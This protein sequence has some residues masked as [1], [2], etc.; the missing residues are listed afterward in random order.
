MTIP[1]GKNGISMNDPHGILNFFCEI[2]GNTRGKRI[3]PF[4]ILPGKLLIR[5]PDSL[6]Y[7]QGHLSAFVKFIQS[8]IKNRRKD[9]IDTDYFYIHLLHF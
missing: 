5:R 6:H 3:S 1:S 7:E 8:F 9:R 4:S 2:L